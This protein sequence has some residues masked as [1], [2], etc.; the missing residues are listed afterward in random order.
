MTNEQKIEHARQAA[1]ALSSFLDP[2]F[3]EV[4]ETYHNRIASICATTPWEANKISA[5]ANA[6]RIAQEVRGQ[7]AAIVAGG[8]V[9]KSGKARAEAIEE[10]S[11]VKRRLL[12]IGPF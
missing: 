5:L 1:L 8:E 9:A 4:I 2:A 6:I 3:E 11:P 7:I 12:R 10:L